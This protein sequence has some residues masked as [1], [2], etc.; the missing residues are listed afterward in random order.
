MYAGEDTPADNGDVPLHATIADAVDD[1]VDH[2]I[3]VHL[4]DC[5]IEKDF[6]EMSNAE[7]ET[8]LPSHVKIKKYQI[9][10]I[11]T[12]DLASRVLD[13]TLEILDEEFLDHIDNQD[14]TEPDEDTKKA[15]Q[16]FAQAMGKHYIVR[17]YDDVKCPPIIVN[18]A[19]YLKRNMS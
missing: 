10:T 11:N 18:K 3:N 12:N 6:S 8:C 19:A 7:R 13:Y 1:A 2:A 9:K 14:P 16:N 5:G 17:A 4:N 15:A